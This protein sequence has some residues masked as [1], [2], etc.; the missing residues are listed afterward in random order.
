MLKWVYFIKMEVSFG[1]FILVILLVF[2][3]FSQ[4]QS[5]SPIAMTD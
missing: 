5:L 4:T 3:Q 1:A 2:W